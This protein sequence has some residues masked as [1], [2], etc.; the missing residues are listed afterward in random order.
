LYR[1]GISESN[2]PPGSTVEFREPTTWQRY[3]AEI[4]AITAAL[5]M[6]TILLV[7]SLYEH[8]RRGIAEA[9]SRQLANDLARMNRFATAGELTA[10][11]AHEIRQPL[12]AIAA[13][14]SASLNWIHADEPDLDDADRQMNRFAP[15]G[16]WIA[17]TA[18]ETRQPLA[19]IA[20]FGSASLN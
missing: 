6:L 18:N 11:I 7:W 8:R 15:A 16:E 17:S 3:R 1:W 14:G 5:A 19:A 2:L 13:F 12:A 4:L 20:A 9:A 10:S